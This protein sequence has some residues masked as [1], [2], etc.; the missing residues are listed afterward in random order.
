M[1]RLLTI[2]EGKD[3][4]VHMGQVFFTDAELYHKIHIQ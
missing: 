1:P 3:L 4:F 2:D